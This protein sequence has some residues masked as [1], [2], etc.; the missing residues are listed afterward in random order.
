MVFT[1]YENDF[2]IVYYAIPFIFF[3]STTNNTENQYTL[4]ELVPL[5]IQEVLVNLI[6]TNDGIPS[7]GCSLPKD[8]TPR[9]IKVYA[10]DNNSYNFLFPVSFASPIY[11]RATLEMNENPIINRYTIN[12]EK[13]NTQKLNFILRINGY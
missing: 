4:T 8:I 2:G 7:V 6:D 3:V 11:N 9:T 10:D 1:D 13:I 12:G 5:A